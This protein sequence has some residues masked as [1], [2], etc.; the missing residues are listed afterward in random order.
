MVQEVRRFGERGER[1]LRVPEKSLC[2]RSGALRR[3]CQRGKVQSQSQ[4]D[5][6]RGK[7]AKT[8]DDMAR[9]LW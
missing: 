9:V 6:K 2:A 4:A 5:R 7:K 3:A 8:V 1:L